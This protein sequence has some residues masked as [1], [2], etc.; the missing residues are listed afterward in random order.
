MPCNDRTEGE[1]RSSSIVRRTLRL[2]A[3]GVLALIALALIALAPGPARADYLQFNLV[4]DGFVP[5]ANIDPNLK[6]PWGISFGPATPFWVSDQVTGKSTLYNGSGTPQA[7][8]V[9]IPPAGGGNP[10]GQVFNSGIAAGAF[11]LPTGGP[12]NFMFATQN[13]T[14]AGWNPAAGTTAQITATAGGGASYTGLAISTG[15]GGNFL[16]AADNANG[17]VDVYNSSFA[18]TTLAGNFTDPSLPSSYVPFNIQNLG[19]QLFVTYM[20]PTLGGG[21]VDVFKLDGTFDH[22]LTSNGA[23]G[24]L[25][26]PWGVA[27]APSTFGQFAN[28]VLVGNNAALD[29]RISAFDATTGAFEGQLKDVLGNPIV[30]TGLWGLTFGNGGQGGDPNVLYIAAGL[31]GEQDGVFA[32]L[33]PAVPEPSSAVLLGLGG[34]SLFG[35]YRRRVWHVA[36]RTA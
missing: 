25:A 12:A 27:I 33:V 6:N 34:A 21:V 31:N 8:V 11:A 10:T 30:N 5:A 28:A 24:P 17:K 15:A 4:S 9:T 16:Y 26:D 1:Q 36:S 22:R 29:G 32:A 20:S 3:P 23:G 35:L 18:P 19:G 7:L 2:T 13:G 14:I